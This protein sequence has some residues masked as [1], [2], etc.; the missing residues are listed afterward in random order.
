MSKVNI[1]PKYDTRKV[2]DLKFYEKNAKKHP[3]KQVKQ[4]ADV[5]RE[6]GFK[7]PVI[8][9]K[10]N[11]IIAGHG[12]VMAA[13]H[14]GLKKVPVVVADDL[15]PVQVK[16]FRLADNRIAESG[17]NK[18][19]IIEE[20]EELAMEG[21][22]LNLTGY[23]ELFMGKDKRVEAEVEFTAELL[24]ENNYIVFAFNNSIDWNVVAD[25]FG[26]ETVQAKDSKKNYRRMG[27]GRIVDGQ[28]LLKFLE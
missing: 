24:E 9:D 13:K 28:A 21:Y 25:Y 8:I 18:K 22:D 26:L 20:L 23:N 19:L 5:I 16:A 11:E 14:L 15:N 1:T 7:V 2:E 3:V 12:R 4:L 6:V 27:V 17:V 10:K